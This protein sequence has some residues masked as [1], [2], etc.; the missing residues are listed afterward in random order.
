LG[1]LNASIAQHPKNVRL[2]QLKDKVLV[3]LGRHKELMDMLKE[4]CGRPD[5]EGCFH[6][7]LIDILI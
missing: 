4:L 2:Y 3:A 6:Q 5:S 1:L 7:R